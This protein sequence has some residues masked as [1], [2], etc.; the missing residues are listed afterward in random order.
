MGSEH[1]PGPWRWELSATNKQLHLVG[2]DHRY[3]LTIMDF[4][5][6]GMWGAGVRMRE[7]TPGHEELNCMFKVHERNDWIA[8]FPNREH[9]KHWCANI[10]H[11]DMRL[12]AA[13]PDL[14]EALETIVGQCEHSFEFSGIDLAEARAAIKKAKGESQC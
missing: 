6:W 10:I 12:M 4:C 3:D 9:H 11:P 5:R 7:T 1:T 14:L 8:A 2:G 13:A